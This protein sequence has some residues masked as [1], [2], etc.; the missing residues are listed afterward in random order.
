MEAASG[1]PA[2]VRITAPRSGSGCRNWKASPPRWSKCMSVRERRVL[3]VDDDVS[4]RGFLAEALRD[5]GYEVQTAGNGHDALALL[6]E[7]RPDL[8]LLDLMMP[9]MDGW[10]FR[11]EQRLIPNMA[12]VPVIVLSATRDLPAK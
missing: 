8:I 3:V 4:I 11:T 1:R 5:E 6:R 2:A 7:W 10:A 9:V 12:D